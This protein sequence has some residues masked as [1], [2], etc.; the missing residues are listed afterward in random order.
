MSYDE[1]H[2]DRDEEG[3][4]FSESKKYS[5]VLNTL[6]ESEIKKLKKFIK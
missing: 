3:T 1:E 6:S 2:E 4:D 5:K